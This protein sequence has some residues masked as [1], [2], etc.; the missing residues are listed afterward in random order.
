[1]SW[2]REGA[3]WA[4]HKGDVTLYA[5]PDRTT[6]VL[7][8]RPARGTKWRAGVSRWDEATRTISRHG[9]DCYSTLCGSAKEA[10]QLAEA[11]FAA[12]EG[13]Q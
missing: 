5:T 6:G 12:A 8:D 11:T 13:A 3:G 1:M 2:Q 10:Q 4:A 7:G 9:R